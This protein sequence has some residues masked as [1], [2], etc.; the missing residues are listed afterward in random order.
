MMETKVSYKVNGTPP[1]PPNFDDGWMEET[2]VSKQAEADKADIH[3]Q[4]WRAGAINL[5][6]Y[7]VAGAYESLTEVRNTLSDLWW[8]Y[9]PFGEDW[10]QLGWEVDR[11]RLE[12]EQYM[13][14]PIDK[15]DI[16]PVPGEFPF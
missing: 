15:R 6:T 3:E 7:K 12:L 1:P 11:A 10:N 9:G 13:P 16:P 5:I 8:N 4:I 2:A 14:V